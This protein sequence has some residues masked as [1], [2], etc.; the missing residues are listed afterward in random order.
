VDELR[1]PLGLDRREKPRRGRV[2]L[3]A[4]AALIVAVSAGLFALAAGL[5]DDDLEAAA[6]I[7]RLPAAPVTTASPPPD[8]PA[9]PPA[10]ALEAAG[11]DSITSAPEAGP[12]II[13]I[14]RD[15]AS[16]AGP[17]LPLVDHDLQEP[18]RHGM[19]P[20]PGPDGRR[21][22]DVY[23]RPSVAG[24]TPTIALL[25]RVHDSSEDAARLAALPLDVTPVLAPGRPQLAALV[26]EVR[27]AGR[28]YVLE[29]PADGPGASSSP[30]ALLADL[31]ASA[32]L[33]HLA[34]SLSRASGFIGVAITSDGA[35]L[36]APGA[37]APVAR[38]VARRGLAFFDATARPDSPLMHV[39]GAD[40]LSA[41]AELA[42]DGRDAEAV[43]RAM[44]RLETV[45][46]M[47]GSALG[48]VSGVPDPDAVRAWVE[49][50]PGRGLRLVPAS[51]LVRH[52]QPS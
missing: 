1:T 45:A 42:V 5:N 47:E 8:L 52:R 21:P 44:A 49:A 36:S 31:P 35:F 29:V 3:Y 34:W 17:A 15:R 16:L 4:L 38:D 22:L 18:S 13:K 10:T 41:R 12:L 40:G 23:A 46:R 26:E 37:V 48:V 50:L 30:R 6:E 14:P 19:V 25:V 43:A 33:D 51:S 20:R 9:A 39:A 27:R 7:R 24:T 11:D 2:F 28:E 32:N